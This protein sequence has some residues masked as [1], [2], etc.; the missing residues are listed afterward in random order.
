MI[1]EPQLIEIRNYLLSKKLPIDI[2]IEVID[3]F[4]SQI[5]DLQREENLSF[6]E[7]FEKTK[8]SWDKELKP[9]W[10]G[11]L[12][13]EDV[14]DF[15]RKTKNEIDKSNLLF[16]FKY[17]TIPFLLIF[18]FAFLLN[19]KYFGYLTFALLASLVMYSIINYYSHY[20]DF[21]L[22]KKHE[23]Y[24]LTLHQ[25]S[26]FI[27]LVIISPMIN[28]YTK[29]LESPE[30]FQKMITFHNNESIILNIFYILLSI[31]LIIFGVFFSISSQKNYLKQIQKVKPFLKYLT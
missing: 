10:K 13:L 19:A 4:I 1:A 7:A 17:S 27:F 24:V 6:D 11:G 3:H 9:Y 18:I 5:S 28:I 16:A 23:K 31:Y 21:K 30:K 25:H 26:V 22:A 29:L 20:Q 15:M 2:L 14:S 12:N 8:L